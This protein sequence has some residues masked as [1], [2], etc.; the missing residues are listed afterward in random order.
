MCTA[1]MWPY[2][3]RREG[4]AHAQTMPKS[5][6]RA[7]RARMPPAARTDSSP[8]CLVAW[9]CVALRAVQGQRRADRVPCAVNDQPRRLRTV[10]AN[11]NANG[12]RAYAYRPHTRRSRSRSQRPRGKAGMHQKTSSYSDRN[13]NQIRARDGGP[14][15]E[16]T[17]ASRRSRAVRAS[18]TRRLSGSRRSGCGRRSWRSRGRGSCAPFPRSGTARW[19]SPRW[20]TPARPSATRPLR[21]W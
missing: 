4:R 6:G 19:R 2:T 5:G 10:I 7:R 9:L 3:C 21:G 13:C 20:S 8:I 14:T 1:R 11:V 18:R 12:P 17:R 15:C 16:A